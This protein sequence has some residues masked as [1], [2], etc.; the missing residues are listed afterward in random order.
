MLMAREAGC[1]ER[2]SVGTLYLLLNF[3]VHKHCFKN[4]VYYIYIIGLEEVLLW[5]SE[6]SCDKKT[7]CHAS[8][9]VVW[10]L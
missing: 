4:K 1:G 9:V 10:T 5:E 8:I 7:C 3:A 6:W 2:G